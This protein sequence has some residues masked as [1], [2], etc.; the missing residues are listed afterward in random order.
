MN[1]HA[2]EDD[3]IF[4]DEGDSE[5]LPNRQQ[6]QEESLT[7][8]GEAQEKHGNIPYGLSQ[9]RQYI[10]AEAEEDETNSSTSTYE[11]EETVEE[12][13]ANYFSNP[14]YRVAS[15]PPLEPIDSEE[16]WGDASPV[17]YKEGGK[18]EDKI[19]GEEIMIK[20]T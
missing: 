20:T 16:D 7:I 18:E 17:R 4:Q 11:E 19:G 8:S 15:P 9:P 6:Q 14:S 10:P 5:T 13:L 3:I 12:E 1:L 2:P